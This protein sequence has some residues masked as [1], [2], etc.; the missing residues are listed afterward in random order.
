M[1][2]QIQ[3]GESIFVVIF[4]VILIVLGL[5]FYSQAREEGT[6]RE[7]VKFKELETISIS[8][9]ASSL[10]ELQCSLQEVQFPNCYDKVKLRAFMNVLGGQSVGEGGNSQYVEDLQKEFY[11]SQLGDAELT[12]KQ[13]Y[14]E[15]PSESGSWELYSNTL[16]QDG[17]GQD[18]RPENVE[19]VDLPI[20]LY[21]GIDGKYAFGILTIKVY[22]R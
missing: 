1:K 19:E 20:S 22:S 17:V 5:V 14:P 18:G 4:I 7:E 9:Y 2:A 21:D 13:V 15:P 3:L 8:Q 11:F 10:S 16:V 12:I 6:N